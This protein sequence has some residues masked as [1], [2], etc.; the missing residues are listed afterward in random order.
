MT[1][2]QVV[3]TNLSVRVNDQFTNVG[4]KLTKGSKRNL[5]TR[6]N[7]YFTSA[8]S[9]FTIEMKSFQAEVTYIQAEIPNL[10]L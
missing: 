7:K 6:V 10:Q 8:T 3:N 5:F 1:N 9:N 2:L 4:A